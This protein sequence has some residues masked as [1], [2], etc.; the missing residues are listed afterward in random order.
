MSFGGHAH[1]QEIRSNEEY[2]VID[3]KLELGSI[4]GN[5][6]KGL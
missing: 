6:W 4:I 3:N 2:G 1:T 5:G